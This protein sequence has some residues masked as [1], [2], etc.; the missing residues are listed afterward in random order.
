MSAHDDY[1]GDSPFPRRDFISRLGGISAATVVGVGLGACASDG[2]TAPHDRPQSDQMPSDQTLSDHALDDTAQ[3]DNATPASAASTPDDASRSGPEAVPFAVGRQA[4][5][6]VATRPAGLTASFDVTGN[7]VDELVAVLS[8]LS[9]E[10]SRLM[11][12][13]P[14]R[15]DDNYRPPTDSGIVG[16]QPPTG[17]AITLAVGSS[18]FDE[19]FGLAERRPR[20]LI[21]MPRFRNDRQMRSNLT[22]GD[23]LFIVSSQ[24]S[25][26][27][28]HVLHQLVRTSNGRLRLRWVQEGY[29]ELLPTN[30]GAPTRNLMGF[31]DGISNL[32]TDQADVMNRHVWV[33]PGDDEPEWAVG[34]TYVAVRVIRMMI[35]FWATAAL[36]RQE[37]I[38]GRHRDTGAP[39]GKTSPTD[40]PGFAGDPRDD[41]V[42][43]RSHMR[44]AN[45]RTPDAPRILRRGFSYLNGAAP[46]GTIDQGLLFIAYQR[47]FT[48][49]FIE[50]Q[51]QLD[52]EPLEDYVKPVGGG[53]WF[54]VPGPGPKADAWLGHQLFS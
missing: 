5:V 13:A 1:D 44:L 21:A 48:T 36:V 47:A 35:E 43:L 9:Q 25:Q 27:A 42:P 32:D 39:L 14:A 22:H 26:S 23:L 16:P 15:E 30:A 54:V 20:E 34:G 37:Q 4:G 10:I 40:E 53:F 12:G 29:N 28:A 49:G 50:V 51:S 46:D 18:L 19:R 24:T 7:S 52:G 31:K 38:F 41:A 2:V 3:D 8:D 45:P 11:A 17:T 33:Q 6:T